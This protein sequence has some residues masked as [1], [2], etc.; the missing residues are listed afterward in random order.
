MRHTN[1]GIVE[2]IPREQDA[3][4]TLITAHY[5]HLEAIF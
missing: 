1:A 4:A 2:D 5:S 3:P